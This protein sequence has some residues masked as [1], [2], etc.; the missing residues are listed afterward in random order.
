MPELRRGPITDRWVI[1]APERAKR[2]SD[3]HTEGNDKS[4]RSPHNCPFCPGNEEMTPPEIHRITGEDGSWRVRVVPNKFP[5]MQ[6]YPELGRT[7]VNGIYDRMN[8]IGTHEVVIETPS[9]DQ[10]IPDLPVE[11]VKLIV[12]AYVLRLQE[13]M[14]NDWYRYVLL[15][16]N[17]GKR[18]GASLSHPHSQIIA[19]P[20][21]PRQVRDRL[22]TAREYYERKER[23]LFCDVM[24]MELKSGERIIEATD[25]FV[26]FTPYDSRF[27]FELV[28]YP[29]KHAHE[30]T[31]ICEEQRWALARIL[32]RTLF[33]LNRLLGDPPYN[34]VL[35]NSPNPIPRP[36]KPGYWATLQYDYHWRI[37]I[38]PRLTTVAGFEWGT[39]LYI[40]PMPPEDAARYLREVEVPED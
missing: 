6:D 23:C 7:A 10:E 2:P 16:K 22:Q 18:A 31:Q 17:H 29:R 12:D 25:E 27:P 33:R 37:A 1:I 8:G 30:F 24:L 34:L 38:I 14:K 13:L 11:Q 26:V 3:Y 35:H 39:G 32:K 21:I 20:V 4:E 28:I 36:G 15:F 40:N 9:H 19:T 5:A